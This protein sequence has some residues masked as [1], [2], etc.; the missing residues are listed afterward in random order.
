MR[1]VLFLGAAL[2]VALVT[3]ASSSS[4]AR[5]AQAGANCDADPT[6]DSEEEA[7][8]QLINDHRAANGVPRLVFSD[9]L[10]QAAAWKSEHMA[11]NDYIG[12]DD[13]GFNRNFVGRLADCGYTANTWLAE[14]LAAGHDTA[15][16]TFEQWRTSPVHNPIMLDPN[17]VAIGVGRAFDAGSTFG[18]YWTTDYGGVAD[19]FTTSPP[20]NPTDDPP[21]VSPTDEPPP[22]SPPD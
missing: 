17:M 13:P 11:T 19:G 18:W 8:F 4:P 12:H 5:V 14:D 16:A 10:N 21:P 15:A 3:I 1:L 22:V 9:T 2:I 7:M 20:V 6:I